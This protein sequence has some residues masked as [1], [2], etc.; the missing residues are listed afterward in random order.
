MLYYFFKYCL[1][2]LLWLIHRPQILGK[3]E[4]LRLKGGV[5]F[6]SN[7]QNLLDPVMIML[8]SP[9]IINFMAKKE[10][11]ENKVLNRIFRSMRGFPVNRRTAD[12]KAL[13][14]A[15]AL[16]DEGEA[17]GIFPEGTRSVTGEMDEFEKG[18]AFIAAKTSAPIV[19][20]YISPSSYKF[21]RRL[22]IIVGECIYAQQVKDT[23]HDGVKLVDALNSRMEGDMHAL[24]A[25]LE[26][27]TGVRLITLPEKAGAGR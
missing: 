2:W 15:L 17:F 9:R 11:F 23:L 27:Q 3:K 10:L 1:K 14:Q 12:M 24:K 26:R 13:K 21:G 20:L 18:T 22:R 7:H 8:V 19:P 6:I 4:N 25:E 5:I 16:L